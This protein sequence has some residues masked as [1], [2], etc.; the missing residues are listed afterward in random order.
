M[1]FNKILS[2]IVSTR[3][4]KI[5]FDPETLMWCHFIIFPKYEPKKKTK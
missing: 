2:K 4:T 3:G 5:S 1:S